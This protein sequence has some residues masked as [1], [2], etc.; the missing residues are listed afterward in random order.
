MHTYK[1]HLGSVNS[2]E[3]YFYFLLDRKQNLMSTEL[4]LFKKETPQNIKYY[5]FIF[6]S[7]TSSWDIDWILI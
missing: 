5:V 3:S 1:L 6:M 2:S 7:T 4:H